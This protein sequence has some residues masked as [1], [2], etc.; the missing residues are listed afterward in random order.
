MPKKSTYTEH[1]ITT[2]PK[3]KKKVN[4]K[5]LISKELEERFFTS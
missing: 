5:E 3:L 1:F 4:I 2:T